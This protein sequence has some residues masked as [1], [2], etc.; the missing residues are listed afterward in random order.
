MRAIMAEASRVV[1]A[2]F[3]LGTDVTITRYPDRY[4]DQRGVVMWDRVRRL[5]E[6]AEVVTEVSSA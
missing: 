2:G 4:S 1:L 3:E 5:I 6:A